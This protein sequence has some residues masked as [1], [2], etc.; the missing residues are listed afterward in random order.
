[1]KMRILITG[2]NS[3]LGNNLANRFLNYDNYIVDKISLRKVD[4]KNLELSK[5]QV[6]FHVAG[7]AH[8]KIKSNN[9]SMYNDINFKLTKQL[10]EKAK[11]SG[12]NHFIFVSSML[13]FN[14][15]ETMINKTTIP[16]PDTLYGKSKL[17]AEKYLMSIETKV[18]K[19]SILRPSMIYGLY[20]RGN[21]QRLIQLTSNTLIF[22]NYPNQRSFLFIEHFI[23]AVESIIKQELSGIYHLSNSKPRST[24]EL[25]K[26]ISKKLNKKV[27][28]IRF[29]NPL[30]SLSLRISKTLNK[31]FGSFYYDESL[32]VHDF[33]YDI[34]SFKTTIQ[35]SI[36]LGER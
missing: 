32:I 13:V 3:Y 6:I 17:M 18:F 7:I 31:M 35:K 11:L 19:V 15:K 20:S 16:K 14:S 29:F 8:T 2:Q 10:A 22:P 9:K 21:F 23:N 33:N 30:I 1:M 5:Y 12:V 27:L 28:F 34:F 36:S 25:V 24:T 26:A 4:V